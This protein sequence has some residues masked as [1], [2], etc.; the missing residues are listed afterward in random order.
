MSTPIRASF[1]REKGMLLPLRASRLLLTVWVLQLVAAWLLVIPI[2]VPLSSVLTHSLASSQMT[3]FFGDPLMLDLI[4]GILPHAGG[5]GGAYVALLP[6]AI[7]LQ[8][9]CHGGIFA[10]LAQADSLPQHRP[11][12]GSFFREGGARFSA[13]LRLS[14]IGII[15]TLVCLAP[16]FALRGAASRL[17]QKGIEETP[18]VWFQLGVTCVGLMLFL[19]SRVWLD[20]SRARVLGIQQTGILLAVN[21]SARQVLRQPLRLCGLYVLSGLPW[22]ILAMTFFALRIALPEPG[23]V[24]ILVAFILGQLALLFRLSVTLSCAGRALAWTGQGAP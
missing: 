19:L 20:L 11:S 7:L 14:L 1:F 13:S 12:L 9:F 24:H 4:M 18:V 5:I 16:W 2:G 3:G 8:I 6:A 23:W 21:A 22:A 15:M 17:A 10:L